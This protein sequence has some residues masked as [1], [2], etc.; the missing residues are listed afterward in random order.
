MLALIIKSILLVPDY[1]DA[2]AVVVPAKFS[3]TR[4]MSN[5]RLELRTCGST[6]DESFASR[7]ISSEWQCRNVVKDWREISERFCS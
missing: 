7:F 6:V 4:L 5:L 2:G 1:H 3:E